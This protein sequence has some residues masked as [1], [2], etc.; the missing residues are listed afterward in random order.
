MTSLRITTANT[1]S[2]ANTMKYGEGSYITL[3]S[4]SDV[5]A[6]HRKHKTLGIVGCLGSTL[7]QQGFDVLCFGVVR[8][9]CHIGLCDVGKAGLVKEDGWTEHAHQRQHTADVV[10]MLKQR[11]RQLFKITL[12]LFYIGVRFMWCSCVQSKYHCLHGLCSTAWL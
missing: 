12:S 9:T 11:R 4:P 1:S 8:V 6:H 5:T 2:T 10:L 7:T 3:F